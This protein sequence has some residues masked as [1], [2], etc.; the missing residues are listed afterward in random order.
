M[1]PR[2]LEAG[3]SLGCGQLPDRNMLRKQ[4]SAPRAAGCWSSAHNAQ[5]HGGEAVFIP[6][7]ARKGRGVAQGPPSSWLVA[8][9]PSNCSGNL[10]KT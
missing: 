10:Y 8:V 5:G 1:H 9:L 6:A 7:R 3:S 2:A 4:L